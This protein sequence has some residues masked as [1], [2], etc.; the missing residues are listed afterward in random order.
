MIHEAKSAPHSQTLP[1][2]NPTLG[3]LV[4]SVLRLQSRLDTVLGGS[5]WLCSHHDTTKR[6]IR[7]YRTHGV[8]FFWVRFQASYIG[9]FFDKFWYILDPFFWCI[10][11]GRPTTDGVLLFRTHQG[12]QKRTYLSRPHTLIPQIHVYLYVAHTTRLQQGF[13]KRQDVFE[14]GSR[15]ESQTDTILNPFRGRSLENH[16]F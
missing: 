5:W 13:I 14:F 1:L 9:C 10:V 11:S 7:K 3:V 2:E 16:H 6:P 12:L 15:Y 4:R 8:L